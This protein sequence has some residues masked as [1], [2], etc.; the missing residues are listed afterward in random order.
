MSFKN[1]DFNL[2]GAIQD[3]NEKRRKENLQHQLY[4]FL[5]N[6]THLNENSATIGA[7]RLANIKG[8]AQY[9]LNALNKE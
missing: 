9:F 6:L 4:L 1:W 8:E 2:F 5:L 3:I 7:G